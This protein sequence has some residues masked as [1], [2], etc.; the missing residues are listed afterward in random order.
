[1]ILPS[2]GFG[3]IR[4][5]QTTLWAA[6]ASL[7]ALGCTPADPREEVEAIW[8]G[9]GTTTARFQKPRAMTIDKDDQLYIV[10]M[11]GRIQV[12]SRDGEYLRSWRTPTIANGKPSG[13]SF[14][15]DGNLLVADTHYFRMLVYTPEGKLLKEKII[16]GECG[17]EPGE[18]NFVTDAVQDSRGHIFIAEYGEHDRIQEFTA[19]GEFVKQWGTHGSGDMQFVRPQNLAIDKHD[20]IWVVD[21]CNH[22][23]Q[24]FDPS[25]TE[26]KLVRTWGEEGSEIGQL[27]YPYDLVLDDDDHVYVCE[28]GNHRVQKFT[29]DGESIAAWGV[30]GRR[31]GE[32]CQPWAVARDS[33]G[34]L[35]ILD[36]YN[37]RVQRIRL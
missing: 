22:R 36:T 24:V 7:L 21:A 10:D 4:S 27:R 29:L 30:S 16:G 6:V 11:T 35:H 31:P 33:R 15:R 3:Q 8:G 25:G 19:G 17:F 28:F 26:A 9:Q 18:F 5:F 13:L 20:H 23:I 37:H 2:I 34:R 1:M 32:L 12:F 14:D